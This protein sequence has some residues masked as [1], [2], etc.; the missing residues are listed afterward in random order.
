MNSPLYV[1]LINAAFASWKKCALA[2]KNIPINCHRG[3]YFL[4]EICFQGSETRSLMTPLLIL[5]FTLL[6]YYLFAISLLNA[7]IDKK[8]WFL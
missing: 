6:F 7:S 2:T 4:C 3:D 1:S 5:A 8:T